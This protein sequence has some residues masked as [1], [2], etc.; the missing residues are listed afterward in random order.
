MWTKAREGTKGSCCSVAFTQATV[1]PP[2]QPLHGVQTLSRVSVEWG[3]GS[4]ACAGWQAQT[5]ASRLVWLPAT[6]HWAVLALRWRCRLPSKH[7]GW[8]VSVHAV[9]QPDAG[10]DVCGAAA[11]PGRVWRMYIQ[12][13][14]A[15]PSDAAGAA[16]AE[17][18]VASG[19]NVEVQD[20]PAGEVPLSTAAEVS[21]QRQGR[22]VRVL[23]QE[24]RPAKACVGPPSDCDCNTAS[25]RCAALTRGCQE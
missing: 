24:S 13:V 6:Q 3:G 17:A 22:V 2:T 4:Q 5:A 14:I 16:L 8:A 20:L 21:W 19:G 7:D 10:G 12:P 11:A 23:S 1:S 25:L 9:Q 15:R 18:Q